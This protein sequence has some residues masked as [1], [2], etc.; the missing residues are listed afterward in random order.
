VTLLVDAFPGG[1][2]GGGSIPA[3]CS[4]AESGNL[5]CQTFTATTTDSFASTDFKGYISANINNLPTLSVFQSQQGGSNYVASGI[6]GAMDVVTGS[7]T[8]QT[9]AVMGIIRNESPGSNA[10]AGYFQ[11]LANSNNAHVWALNPLCSTT[12]GFTGQICQG[13]EID[14]N[15]NSTGDTLAGVAL[16]GI[17]SAV[18]AS[19]NGFV[20]SSIGGTSGGKWNTGFFASGGCCNNAVYISQIA[21]TG[22]NIPSMP[23]VFVSTNSGGAGQSAEEYLDA[24]GTLQFTPSGGFT[25]FNGSTLATSY[26]ALGSTPIDLIPG[27][28]AT[29]SL[30]VAN[31]GNTTNVFTIDPSGN[32]QA[33]GKSIANGFATPSGTVIPAAAT[34][35]HGTGS[36]DVKVQLSDGT[37]TFT[38]VA[39]FDANGGLMDG[40]S[41]GTSIVPES[42]FWSVLNN[43]DTTGP[44]T[45]TTSDFSTLTPVTSSSGGHIFLVAAGRDFSTFQAGG[46]WWRSYTEAGSS[47]TWQYIGLS[48]SSDLNNWTSVVT[49]NWSS[50]FTGSET[51]IWQGRT[52]FDPIGNQL[53]FYFGTAQCS[54]GCTNRPWVTTFSPANAI[55]GTPF[56]TPSLITLS[57]TNTFAMLTFVWYN[58]A[59]S[60][61][62]GL[63]QNGTSRSCDLMKA[64]SPLGPFTTVATG[65]ALGWLP[66]GSS[67]MIE[68]CDGYIDPTTGNITALFTGSPNSGPYGYIYKSTCTVPASPETCS[69]STPVTVDSATFNPSGTVADWVD[70]IPTTSLIVSGGSQGPN[71]CSGTTTVNAPGT[72]MPSTSPLTAGTGFDE[73]FANAMNNLTGW[74][75]NGGMVLHVFPSSVNT[76]GWYV[77]N[78][79]GASISYTQ[80]NFSVK[81][82]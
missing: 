34:G 13:I 74:G 47:S 4:Q 24:A 78:Q 35:Y 11:A 64:S 32:S 60:S 42:A 69:W 67:P 37:G 66:T 44:I 43:A 36:G 56:G 70:A 40:G 73:R 39:V 23:I 41:G 53:L 46:Y 38:H 19:S 3:G 58:A 61:Y 68:A 54:S 77:C 79:S 52:M 12:S 15:A 51:S 16:N 17:W 75:A 2:G 63:L 1:G 50:L 8:Y 10:V 45:F 80:A 48:Y 49:P 57:P 59:N 27:A 21:A 31:P 28:S 71:S 55:T 76:L 22:N 30:L 5:T 29:Y 9:N 65:S 7:S 33:L 20:I 25:N 26:R 72:V 81:G 6:S 14:M 82:N 18:P 62:Y